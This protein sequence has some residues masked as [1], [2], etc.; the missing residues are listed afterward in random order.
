M[1]KGKTMFEYFFAKKLSERTRAQNLRQLNS[2]LAYDGIERRA[3]ERLE[4]DYADTATT[5]PKGFVDRRAA[6]AE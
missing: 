6:A 5:L 3:S 2:A 1:N 4:S